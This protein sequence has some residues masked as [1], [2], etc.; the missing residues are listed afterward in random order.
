M[1]REASDLEE[2]FSGSGNSVA[3]G[4]PVLQFAW[5]ALAREIK[6]GAE[7][8][9]DPN[10][11]DWLKIGHQGAFR[12]AFEE[13]FQ[14]SVPK[15]LETRVRDASSDQILV[16]LDRL[17]TAPDLETEFREDEAPDQRQ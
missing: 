14:Q 13:R 16:W 8:F 10:V 11:Q 17:H 3:D 4:K 15:H 7:A 9:K 12:D 1:L 6:R 2:V 5:V